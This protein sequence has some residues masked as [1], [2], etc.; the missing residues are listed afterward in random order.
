MT[1]CGTP[2]LPSCIVSEKEIENQPIN[3]RKL[4]ME[5]DK[6]QKRR[7]KLQKSIK[8]CREEPLGKAPVVK[9]EDLGLICDPT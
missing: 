6:I 8:V 2:S 3:G 7:R 9:P 1:S 4:E 5:L